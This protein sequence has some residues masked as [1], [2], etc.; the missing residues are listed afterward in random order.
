MGTG[1]CSGGSLYSHSLFGGG[2]SSHY[3]RLTPIPVSI[4]TGATTAIMLVALRRLL[5][6]SIIST[7]RAEFISSRFD[8]QRILWHVI[9][10]Q[11]L[12]TGI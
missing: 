4:N 2:I 10:F 6:L 1:F 7:V 12:C 8:G 11:F 9:V 5:L 3:I